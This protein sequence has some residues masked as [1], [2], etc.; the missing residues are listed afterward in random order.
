MLCLYICFCLQHDSAKMYS[1]YSTVWKVNYTVTCTF[2]YGTFSM[3][4]YEMKTE[5]EREREMFKETDC[6]SSVQYCAFDWSISHSAC[7]NYRV[8]HIRP[9]TVGP[10]ATIESIRLHTFIF[11]SIQVFMSSYHPYHGK[12]AY[13]LNPWIQIQKY[14][15]KSSYQKYSIN[16]YVLMKIKTRSS[17]RALNTRRRPKQRIRCNV[18]FCLKR[19]QQIR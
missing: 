6:R 1:F 4:W 15:S 17:K 18:S 9:R 2:K 3:K 16:V 5:K 10:T 12:S 19:K 11:P 7:V 14:T 13:L 8:A